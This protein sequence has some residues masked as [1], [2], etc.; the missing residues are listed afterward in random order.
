MD[1][2]FPVLAGVVLGLATHPLDRTWLRI[3]MLG[4]FGLA[5]GAIASWISGELAIS[6]IYLLIDT[7]QVIG[8]SVMTAV[9]V[10]VWRRRR[11]AGRMTG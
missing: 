10:A 1:E 5:F 3:A 9:L 8:V 11:T 2:V 6:W 7:A 4:S